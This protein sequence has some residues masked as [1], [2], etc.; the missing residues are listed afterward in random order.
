MVSLLLLC[1][2]L[3]GYAGP[4]EWIWQELK[5]IS[6]LKF[7]FHEEEDAMDYVTRLAS[8]MHICE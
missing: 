1:C 5:S 4:Q 8:N 3:F 2:S 7:L 6:E